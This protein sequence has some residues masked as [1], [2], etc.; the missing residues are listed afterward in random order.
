MP[1]CF[2]FVDPDPADAEDGTVRALCVDCR[3]A[4]YRGRGWF[5]DGQIGPWT[6]KCHECG[7]CIQFHEET[8]ETG[9]QEASPA[10]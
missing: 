3:T 2:F 9:R 6:V 5:H 1:Q 10:V 7:C 8:H 4:K